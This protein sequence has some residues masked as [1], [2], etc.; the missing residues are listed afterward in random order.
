VSCIQPIS[1]GKLNFNVDRSCFPSIT[2]EPPPGAHG[3]FNRLFL[4]RQNLLARS[5]DRASWFSLFL[6]FIAIIISIY[7]AYNSHEQNRLTETLNYL[8]IDPEVVIHFYYPD[9][10]NSNSSPTTPVENIGSLNIVALGN[11]STS[12][13]PWVVVKNDGPISIVSLGVT[14]ELFSFDKIKNNITEKM[15]ITDPANDFGGNYGIFKNTLIPKES[16]SLPLARFSD[17]RDEYNKTYAISVYVFDLDYYRPSDM[18]YYNKRVIFFYDNGTVYRDRDFMNNSYY[19][20]IMNCIG[21]QSFISKYQSYPP[22]S[23]LMENIT[24]SNG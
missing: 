2:C 24:K 3:R 20:S 18:K 17:K 12:E 23:F 10:N 11:N 21:A 6:S 14:S 16:V 5:V 4:Y 22:I 7:A 9:F 1:H 8:T 19:R 13:T 15:G